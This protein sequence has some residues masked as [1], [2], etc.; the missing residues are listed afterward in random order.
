FFILRAQ[1]RAKGGRYASAKSQPSGDIS[2]VTRVLLHL[3]STSQPVRKAP[4]AAFRIKLNFCES[5]SKSS[6]GV[7]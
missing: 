7:A 3:A 6:L 1:A 2:V 4:G 5:T